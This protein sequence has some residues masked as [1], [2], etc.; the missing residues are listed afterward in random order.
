MAAI[1]EYAIGEVIS[2]LSGEH[3]D[4]T[5]S[6]IR[7]LED[8]GLVSPT[9]TPTGYR[10]FDDADVDRLRWILQ[11]QREHQW[12]LEQLRGRLDE[13][14]FDPRD[15]LEE[16]SMQGP[17]PVPSLFDH[18]EPEDTDD[19]PAVPSTPETPAKA[20]K[21][22]RS[23]SKSA[24]AVGSSASMTAGE[25]A[26][27][28]GE[29]IH[30]INQLDRLGLI[31]GLRTDNGSVYGEDSLLIAKAAAS[32]TSAG[33][34]VRHLRMYRVA[35]DREA[36]ILAQLKSAQ[37]RKGGAAGDSARADLR[38]LA[39]HGDRIRRAILHRELGVPLDG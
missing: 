16:R 34:E 9:R 19:E 24:S 25:L 30:F 11:Q 2:L 13:P 38:D 7:T 28:V 37:L 23:P 20:P 10:S 18:A 4:V 35:A 12:S 15:E 6:K 22:R 29:S 27:A 36:G 39:D 1:R 31:E 33:L 26:G 8:E 14:G 5:I 3:P 17:L 21:P 32:L